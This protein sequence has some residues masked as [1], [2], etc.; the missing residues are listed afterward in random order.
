METNCPHCQHP[1]KVA[2]FY[3][4]EPSVNGKNEN[5]PITCYG[6]GKEYV[7]QKLEAAR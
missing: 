1:A 3:A 2:G 5:N 6:C 4:K 7:P